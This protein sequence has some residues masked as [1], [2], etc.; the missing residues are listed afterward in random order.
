MAWRRLSM[1]SDS[2]EPSDGMLDLGGA[3]LR[4]DARRSV[5]LEVRMDARRSEGGATAGRGAGDGFVDVVDVVVVADV[6]RAGGAP[7]GS[8]GGAGGA[9]GAAGVGAPS[10][11][12]V[13]DGELGGSSSPGRKNA[14]GDNTSTCVGCMTSGV[15]AA[16]PTVTL[17]SRSSRSMTVEETRPPSTSSSRAPPPS[18]VNEMSTSRSS[19]VTF[20][21]GPRLRRAFFFL[22]RRACWPL[23]VCSPSP[24]VASSSGGNSSA[25]P[26][27]STS[28]SSSSSSSS[29][30][31]SSRI[32]LCFAIIL[33]TM[34]AVTGSRISRGRIPKDLKKRFHSS[35]RFRV[36]NPPSSS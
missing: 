20:S 18:A 7:D 32:C 14:S 29:T 33:S 3:S 23:V 36:S 22:V 21:S 25:P 35:G 17:K 24:T 26:S 27:S 10:P 2:T 9:R 5:W 12:D 31:K 34:R 4:S 13:G 19:A 8:A 11:V 15:R 6:G 16:S 28:S 30:V 1:A